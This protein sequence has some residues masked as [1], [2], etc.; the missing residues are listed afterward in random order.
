MLSNKESVNYLVD[1]YEKRVIQFWEWLFFCFILKL[2]LDSFDN[3]IQLIHIVIE[4]ASN[5]QRFIG[6]V[7]KL[8]Y[9]PLNLIE[10]KNQWVAQSHIIIQ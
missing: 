7:L 1:I 4:M 3:R 9:K 10:N 5:K 8:N 6:V 2:I